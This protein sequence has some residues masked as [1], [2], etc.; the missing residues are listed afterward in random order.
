MLSIARVL[1]PWKEAASLNAQLNLY[2]F[3]DA[4]TFLTKSGDLGIVLRVDGVDYESLDTGEQ[5]YAVKRLEAALKS[6][7]PG[8]HV[9]QYLFKRNRP[10]IPF[11]RYED[12]VVAAANE[13]RRQFF[14][15]KRDQLYSVEIYY[16][17]LLEGMRSKTGVGAGV[18]RL[19]TDPAGGLSELRSQF[20]NKSMKV[21]LASQI[22]RDCALLHQRV[23]AFVRQLADFVP[24]EILDQGGQ[25]EFFRRLLNFDEWR[26]A[27]KPKS[28]QFLD[29][30]VV[31]SDIEAERDHLRVGDHFVRVLTMKEAIAETRP[32]VLDALLKISAN[33]HVVTEWVP[34]SMAKARKE[35]VKR[36]RHFNISKTGFISQLG[37]DVTKTN[38]RDVVVDESKQADIENLGDCLRAMGDGQSLGDFSLTIILYD[39][40]KS[41]VDRLVGE[42]SGIFTN[43]DGNLFTE[44]YNQLNAYFATSVPAEQQLRRSLVS[45]YYPSWRKDE[46]TPRRGISRGARN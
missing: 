7:G 31:N 15:A 3:W 12:Q 38:P 46:P 16:C 37:N 33:F 45:L 28:T 34:L 4:T 27:G 14:E 26:I 30:Q 43:F 35:V 9:Y 13:Q 17:V 36:R 24:M 21:L 5:E 42:F 40:E 20:S 32:L 19:I 6:F 39:H 41:A 10:E 8:F 11:G 44:T 18:A 1:K 22:Q 2:G 23:Q 29:Y 25:L